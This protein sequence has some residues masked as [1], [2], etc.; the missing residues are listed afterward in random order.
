LHR[1]VA[2]L[3]LALIT[4]C[5]LVLVTSRAEAQSRVVQPKAFGM[6]EHNIFL[7]GWPTAP[8]GSFR[9]WDQ[10]PNVTWK[11]IERS[12][13]R[14]DWAK[15]DALVDRIS[16]KGVDIVY[17]F[18]KTPSWAASAPTGSCGHAPP[19]TCYPPADH[20][21]WE[22]FVRAIT[23]RYRGKI[24]YW[25]LWNEPNSAN[26][27]SGTK[28]QLV[29]LAREAYP[30]ITGNGGIVLSPSPQGSTAD[31]WIS[32]YLASG[33]G[34]YADI[35]AFHGYLGKGNSNL[36]DSYGTLINRVRTVMS[37][38]GQATKELWDTECSWGKQD[39]YPDLELQASWLVRYKL[40]SFAGGIAR[41]F[42]Y[43]WSDSTWG[44]LYDKTTRSV[45]PAGTSYSV[46]Y[47][48]LIGAKFI[49]ACSAVGTIWTCN[50]ILAD[51]TLSQA[52]WDAA[53]TCSGGSCTASNRIVSSRWTR[54]RDLAG[55]TMSIRNHL[56]PVGIKPVLLTAS[57]VH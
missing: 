40:L 54:Y 44:T 10:V 16:S 30:I 20:R 23:R 41:S 9:I 19:G 12:R 33:G 13:G 21:D 3:A 52:M 15:L 46:V 26:F 27:W 50:L 35:I 18:G 47:G 57:T 22:Q 43:A 29:T 8:V 24:R 51:G 11:D 39:E 56:V 37:H 45:R 4:A 32:Q 49:D 55:N 42:W 34:A 1:T 38:H 14:Y 6:H 31:T 7:N 25:E 36:E 48:W 17:T 5:L 28:S 53:K 2:R